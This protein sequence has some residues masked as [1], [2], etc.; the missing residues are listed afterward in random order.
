MNGDFKP[1]AHPFLGGATTGDPFQAD[2]MVFGAPHGTPYKGTSNTPFENAADAL[3]SAL[4]ADAAWLDHWNFDIDAPLR[5]TTAFRLA[6]A[7]NLRTTP[8]DGPGNRALIKNTVERAVRG[9]AI[10][11]MI[12]GDDSTPIPFFQG[13]AE[14]GPLTIVQVDAHI[15]WRD[16]RFGEPLGFSS[17]MRRASEMA[18]V[19]RIIQVG[20][21]GVGSARREEVEVAR[22]WGADIVTA[23]EVHRHGI[24]RALS[25][26]ADGAR[27]VIT[28]DCDGLDAGIMPAVISPEPGGL[29]YT[30][31]IE[32]IRGVIGK[33]RLV[34]L[35]IIEF[36]PER[37]LTGTAAIT[38]ARILANAIGMLACRK[39]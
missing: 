11:L 29:S 12:G 25:Q 1:A 37:D 35:D 32:L 26:L 36:V 6:D 5:D 9:G 3:R 16:E 30:Q 39:A 38:A 10:P 13:L 34:G 2:A 17:T 20:I 8:D 27:C 15:D 28:I 24:E 7:G 33:A 22:A 23:R 14:C 21:R 18:H 4:Q 31:T 19:E